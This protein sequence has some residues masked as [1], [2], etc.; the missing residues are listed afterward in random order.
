MKKR[1]KQ[2]TK[3]RR[4][5]H[6]VESRVNELR[7]TICRQACLYGTVDIV[8]RALFLKYNKRL[9]ELQKSKR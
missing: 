4:H 8:T 6:Y 1:I 7:N 9:Q 3:Y 5:H 2:Y